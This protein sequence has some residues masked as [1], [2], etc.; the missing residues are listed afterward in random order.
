MYLILGV[1]L[2][3]SV[4]LFVSVPQT[5]FVVLLPFSST[6]SINFLSLFGGQYVMLYED[7]IMFLGLFF[8]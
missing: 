8:T 5:A 1:L 4:L 2:V 6:Q 3:L 7:R